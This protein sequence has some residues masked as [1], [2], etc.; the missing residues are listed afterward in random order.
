MSPEA[1]RWSA[2]QKRD[3]SFDG[4]F[5]YAVASTRIYCRPS[6]S[7]RRP[8]RSRVEFYDT[9]GAAEKAGYRACKRCKPGTADAKR[10]DAAVAKAARFLSSNEGPVT[11]AVLS[12]ETGVSPFH[13]QR[14]F[15][16]ALG[17]S[18][19]AYHDAERRR[20]LAKHLRK[21][22]TVS[23]ATYEAGFGSSSR[24]YERAS[25]R[26]GMTPAAVRRGGLGERIHFVIVSSSLGRVLVG[27]T[28]KG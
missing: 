14:A 20:R 16:R 6:C 8:T 12:R 27:W 9:P 13:L 4:R 1:V 28:E 11:L 21:G 22:D 3:A 7:S 2:V 10:I 24:V 5:V 18:P 26:L 15:K 25:T 23:R 19:K 17:V